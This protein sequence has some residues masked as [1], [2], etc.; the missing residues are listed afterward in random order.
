[1]VENFLKYLEFE[2]RYSKHTLAAYQKDLDQLYEFLS[3]TFEISDPV[4][5]LHPHLRSW[6][7]QLVDKGI[8][9]KSINRKI[10]TLKSYFKFLMGREFISKNPAGRLKPLKTEKNLPTFVKESE[11]TN[12]LTNLEFSED[13]TGQRDKLVI[14]LFYSTGIRLAE[15]INIKISDINFFDKS[16]K[17][18]GKRN[19][20]RIIP[21][22]SEVLRLTKNYLLIMKETFPE[23]TSDHLILTDNGDPVYPVFIYRLIKKY[24]GLVTTLTKKSPHVLRHTFATHMLDKGADLNAVKDLLGHTSLAATQVYTHNSLEKLKT[25]FDQAHPKA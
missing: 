14:E 7:V 8:S 11:M 15:L 19:K 23:K 5:V 16:V 9:P 4:D 1:M 6:V 25:A 17:V 10:A 3:S 22:H 24:L 12:L 18:L 20:E 13:F 21:L 2:K